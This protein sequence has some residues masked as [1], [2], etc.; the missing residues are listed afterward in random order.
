LPHH[1]LHVEAIN[2]FYSGIGIID[3]K[4]QVKLDLFY[5]VK[6][7]SRVMPLFAFFGEAPFY[8]FDTQV[9]GNYL[10]SS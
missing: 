2:C 3:N 1:V 7:P 4:I 5:G 9:I 8:L 10:F 6:D